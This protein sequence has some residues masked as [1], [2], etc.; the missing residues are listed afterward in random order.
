MLTQ[1]LLTDLRIASP[2]SSYILLKSCELSY[3]DYSTIIILCQP[4][5]CNLFKI[6]TSYHMVLVGHRCLCRFHP[7]WF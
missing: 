3:M 2:P 6:F 4:P 7:S 1:I 5:L